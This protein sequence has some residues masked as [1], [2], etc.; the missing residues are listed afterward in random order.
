[1]PDREKIESAITKCIKGLCELCPYE[2]HD[3]LMSVC[4]DNLMVD[5]LALLKEQEARVLTLE[6]M[7]L[8]EES[9]FLEING[10]DG[11]IVLIQNADCCGLWDFLSATPGFLHRCTLQAEDYNKYW[12][13]WSKRPT[14]EHRMEVPWNE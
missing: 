1:M 8:R 6:E 7:E 2:Q 12:R 3:P 13:C 14:D 9:V 4:R 5:A 10:E 11:A